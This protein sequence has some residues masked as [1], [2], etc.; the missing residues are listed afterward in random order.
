MLC[1]EFIEERDLDQKI[2]TLSSTLLKN[3][4]SNEDPDLNLEWNGLIAGVIYLA[5][6]ILKRSISQVEISELVGVDNHTL[7]KRYRE[8]AKSLTIE[9]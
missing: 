9:I 4:I 2:G 6:R 7:S 1:F 8:I 3:F 5:C